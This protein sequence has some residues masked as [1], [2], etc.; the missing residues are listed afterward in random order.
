MIDELLQQ[1]QQSLDEQYHKGYE[2][3]WNAVW[4]ALEEFLR[5]GGSEETWRRETAEDEPSEAADVETPTADSERPASAERS[6]TPAQQ[7]ALDYI[8]SIEADIQG[9][10]R[11]W[12][13]YALCAAQDWS[14]GQNRRAV[15]SGRVRDHRGRGA[16]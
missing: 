13:E 7:R 1:I 5:T 3:G 6:L 16:R 2:D 10:S 12:Q 15:L 8:T 11:N 4:N 14:V 9:D